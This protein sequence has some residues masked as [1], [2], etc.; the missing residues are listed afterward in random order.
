[1]TMIQT[2]KIVL[3]KNHT[4]VPG[5][6][7]MMLPVVATDILGAE[8]TDRGL[9]LTFSAMGVGILLS[10]PSMGEYL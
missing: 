4:S 8:D 9:G 7:V 5:T 3:N 1:M 10:I 6:F 2:I